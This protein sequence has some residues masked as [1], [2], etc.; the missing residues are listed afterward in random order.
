MRPRPP[1]PSRWLPLRQKPRRALLSLPRLFR[2]RVLSAAPAT[3]RKPKQWKHPL[4]QHPLPRHLLP[5]R[6]Q[7]QPRPQPSQRPRLWKPRPKSPLWIKPKLRPRPPAW[8][9]PMPRP[10]P[11][12]L[13]RLPCRS[14]PASPA[15]ANQLK[16]RKTAQHPAAF[17]VA[18]PL[19]HRRFVLFRALCPVLLPRR[20]PAPPVQAMAAPAAIRPVTALA[21]LVVI[22]PVTALA[23]PV[24]IRRVPVVI[25]RVP[26]AL[27]APVVSV[28]AALVA[29][30]APVVRRVPVA[31]LAALGSR[32]RLARPLIPATGRA[33]RSA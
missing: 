15:L 29:P 10:C 26:V 5:P 9:A 21:G 1:R 18:M 20:S 24:V 28:L 30:V 4:P 13:L 19:P 8:R 16:V 22:R 25:R 33:K 32:L 17:F 14:V 31:Q 6:L 3:I 11:K 12:V 2:P 27:V 23:G 7:K